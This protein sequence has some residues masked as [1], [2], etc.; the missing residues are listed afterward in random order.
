MSRFLHPLSFNFLVSYSVILFPVL[1]ICCLFYL[2]FFSIYFF[3]SFFFHFFIN[4]LG[5]RVLE[6]KASTGCQNH[7]VVEMNQR[8]SLDSSPKGD[9]SWKFTCRLTWTHLPTPQVH[10]EIWKIPWHHGL[11]FPGAVTSS[12]HQPITSFLPGELSPDW[13]FLQDVIDPYLWRVSPNGGQ[14]RARKR[15]RE[16]LRRFF[17]LWGS[18]W[19][20]R[21]KYAL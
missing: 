11:H 10:L 6:E 1:L 17:C 15:D 19:Q 4:G 8:F 9:I 21:R 16:I 13:Y 18:S 12:M 3:P 20:Q 2:F 5:S 14:K 7:S